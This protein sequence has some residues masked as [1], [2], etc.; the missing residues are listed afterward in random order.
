MSPRKHE[1]SG[2]LFG[3]LLANCKKRGET[4][5]GESGQFKRLAK[6]LVEWPY[7]PELVP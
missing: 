5:V 4:P 6:R 2:E 1:V 3:R 7:D